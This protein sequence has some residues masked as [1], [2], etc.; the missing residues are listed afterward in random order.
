MFIERC[1]SEEQAKVQWPVEQIEDQI[2]ME[3]APN[4]TLSLGFFEQRS[5][6]HPSPFH[7][8]GAKGGENLWFR[9]PG[10]DNGGH[11]L[12]QRAAEDMCPPLHLLMDGLKHRPVRRKT[13]FILDRRDECGN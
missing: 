12:P 4:L 6:F 8:M 9:L 11:D 5:R 3:I 1:M 13:Q 2:G 10:A 7:P